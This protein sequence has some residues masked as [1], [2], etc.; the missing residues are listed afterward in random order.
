MI[1]T[2]PWSASFRFLAAGVIVMG[3]AA[4][5]PRTLAAQSAAPGD[6]LQP[7]TT[8][9]IVLD[10]DGRLMLARP[11]ELGMRDGASQSIGGMFGPPPGVGRR[12]FTI[13]L[14]HHPEWHGRRA[15]QEMA[16]EPPVVREV[17]PG[18]QAEAAGLRAGDVIVSVNGTDSRDPAQWR[19]AAPGTVLAMHVRGGGGERDVRV[20]VGPAPTREEIERG[21]RLRV[22]CLRRAF[23]GAATHAAWL[24]ASRACDRTYGY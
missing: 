11:V 24:E 20:T 2:Q 19:D 13:H 4:A 22:A 21:M 17:D 1:R 3:T 23:P 7:D 8:V 16:P 6:A 5:S 14:P 9:A 12:G 10:A 15:Q 18:S